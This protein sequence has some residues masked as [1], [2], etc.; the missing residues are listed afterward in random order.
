M[1]LE[2]SAVFFADLA[3]ETDENLQ[4][5]QTYL[6]KAQSLLPQILPEKMQQGDI[7]AQIIPSAPEQGSFVIYE[8]IISAIYAA[9]KQITI[10]TPY[11]VPDEP[12]LMALTVAAKRGVKCV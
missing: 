2:L 12:L 7:V 4:N 9:T 10:T 3:V 5:V 6:N 11:F 8:T 1:V